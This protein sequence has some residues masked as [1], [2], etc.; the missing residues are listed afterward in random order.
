MTNQKKNFTLGGTEVFQI[1]LAPSGIDEP[2]N[3]APYANDAEYCRS[4]L[5]L[6]LKVSGTPGVIRCTCSTMAQRP[7]NS[8]R[9]LIV[10]GPAMW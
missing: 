8:M 9:S 5:S 1:S 10:R 6:Q 2:T 3:I 4:A 7:M